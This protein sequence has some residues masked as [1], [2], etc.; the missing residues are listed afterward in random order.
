MNRYFFKCSRCLLRFTGDVEGRNSPNVEA[1]PV[2]ANLRVECLGSTMGRIVMTV[3]CN[4]KCVFAIG[5]DCSCS[6][7]GKNHG[8]GLLVPVIRGV[9]DFA[10]VRLPGLQETAMNYA[11]YAQRLQSLKDSPPE[12][13]RVAIAAQKAGGWLPQGHYDTLC[14]WKNLIHKI[15]TCGTY[16]GRNKLIDSLSAVKLDLFM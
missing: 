15:K 10:G 8:S 7:G 12:R 14:E 4:D 16:A 6:C 11:A 13:F 3:P 1:C 5:N 2:C 9:V